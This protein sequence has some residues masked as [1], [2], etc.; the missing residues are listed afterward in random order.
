[1]ISRTLFNEFSVCFFNSSKTSVFLDDDRRK[2]R[3]LAKEWQR[4][5]RNTVSVMR[6]EV[7][8]YQEKIRVLETRQNELIKENNELRDL[9]VYLDQQRSGS[10]DGQMNSQNENCV[11]LL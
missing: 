4:F 3:K 8:G 10:I 7:S 5:G 11:L 6:G 1:M 9:C 2:C